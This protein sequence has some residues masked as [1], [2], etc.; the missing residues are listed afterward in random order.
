MKTN[1]L[2][3]AG[4]SLAV[5]LMTGCLSPKVPLAA[6]ENNLLAANMMAQPDKAVVYVFRPAENA[7]LLLLLRIKADG[8]FKGSLARKTYVRLDLSEGPHLLEGQYSEPNHPNAVAS[9]FTKEIQCRSGEIMFF[10]PKH[11]WK[12]SFRAVSENTGRQWVKDF[13][14]TGLAGEP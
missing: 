6:K 2:I 5:C 3:L 7:G 11:D 9:S 8:A 10:V 13:N 4:T 12:H 14:L 1:P